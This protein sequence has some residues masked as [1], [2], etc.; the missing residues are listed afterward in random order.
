VAS[1]A[2]RFAWLSALEA[3]KASEAAAGRTTKGY[4][5]G[6]L[7]L[8]ATLLADR[9]AYDARKA[10]IAARVEAW[11]AVT[12]LRLDAHDLWHDDDR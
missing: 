9:Q 12:R 8:A 3:A 5:L 11:R 1:D 2:A 6:E 10:E 4:E 7:D